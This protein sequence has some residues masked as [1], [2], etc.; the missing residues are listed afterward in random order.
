MASVVEGGEPVTEAEDVT[1]SPTPTAA[2][3]Q[4]QPQAEVG[5]DRAVSLNGLADEHSRARARLNAHFLKRSLHLSR[6]LV[7]KSKKM[8]TEFWERWITIPQKEVI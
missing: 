7:E 4:P 8:K 5:A 1:S 3:E 6:F 2:A